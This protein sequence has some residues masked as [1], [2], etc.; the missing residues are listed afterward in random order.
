MAKI[1]KAARPEPTISQASLSDMAF[2]LLIFFIVT[3]VFVKEKGI[4][5]TLP[6]AE[7]IVKIA[8]QTAVTIY[9][10]PAGNISIDDFFVDIPMVENV[11]LRKI[12]EDYNMVG[13]FRTD[14]DTPYGVMADVMNQMRR[15]N[16][17]RVSFEAKHKR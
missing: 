4:K 13:A 8:R 11:M 12:N 2:L 9:V 7:D 14:Q 10:D 6:R 1:K 3:T 15:A 16:A 17:L 5:V